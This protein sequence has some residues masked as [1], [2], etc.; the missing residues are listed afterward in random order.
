MGRR[1]ICTPALI[2][3]FES[4]IRE[5]CSWT[6]AAERAGATREITYA[7]LRRGQSG[8]QP[9]AEFAGRTAAAKNDPA[10]QQA[11]DPARRFSSR[12]WSRIDRRAPHDCW[13]WTGPLNRTTGYGAIRKGRREDGHIGVHRAV[14]ELT[15]GPVPPRTTVKQTCG[16]KTCCNPEHLVLAGRRRGSPS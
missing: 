11:R 4:A 1:T 6:E 7:W 15:Y 14:W 13:H 5:G 9:Y 2:N 16:H 3:R 12:L 10:T 8:E